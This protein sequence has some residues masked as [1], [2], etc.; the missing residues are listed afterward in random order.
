[1]EYEYSTTNL[2]KDSR[3]NQVKENK[4]VPRKEKKLSTEDLLL[5]IIS[6]LDKL[7]VQH[8]AKLELAS[9]SLANHS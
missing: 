8:E 7:E 4:E 3:T 9:S 1:M 6:R 2:N 5:G